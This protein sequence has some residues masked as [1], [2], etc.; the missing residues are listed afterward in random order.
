VNCTGN[1]P[2]TAAG[3]LAG[4]ALYASATAGGSTVHPADSAELLTYCN[5]ATPVYGTEFVVNQASGGTLQFQPASLAVSP[6]DQLSLSVSVTP[7]GATLQ[8]SDLDTGHS[9]SA[10]GPGFVASGGSGVLVG[11]ITADGHG[12]PLITGARAVGSSLP[13][14]AG[15]VPSSPV[16]FDDVEIDGKPLSSVSGSGATLW[17]NSA[18]QTVARSTPIFR[19][20]AFA[21][22][23]GTPPPRLDA[24][25]DVAPVSGRVFVKLPGST[26][27]VPLQTVRS[28]PIGSVIDARSGSVQVTVATPGGGTQSAVF[29]DGEFILRQARDGRL[30]AVL[31]GGTFAGCPTPRPR[32]ASDIAHRASAGRASIAAALHR[33]PRR[34]RQLWANAHGSFSTQGEYGSAAVS[35]TEWLTADQCN[36][37]YFFVKRHVIVVTS[38][39]LHNRKTRVRTGRHYLAPA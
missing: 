29:F 5:G 19:T 13:A 24:T 16:V 17:T 1:P 33:K 12:N 23:F 8:I 39:R 10:S 25:A 27:F 6:G 38:F 37:T 14:L 21:V 36:G 34:V 26:R 30:T 18:G 7:A 28:I 31:T 22:S 3:Q 4:V 32:G 9:T 11:A 35:G 20:N 2:G 15:P